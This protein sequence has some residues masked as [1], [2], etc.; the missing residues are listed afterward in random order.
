MSHCCEY[1][2]GKKGMCPLAQENS[3]LKKQVCIF[4]HNWIPSNK[5]DTHA[6]HLMQSN[7]I[8]CVCLYKKSLNNDTL[9]SILNKS[10][11]KTRLL[12]NWRKKPTTTQVSIE[13]TPTHPKQ[14]NSCLLAKI[15]NPNQNI[16]PRL[17]Y[18]VN[19]NS[20]NQEKKISPNN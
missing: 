14:I 19:K 11:F 7:M 9:T 5:T 15:W 4:F 2:L 6:L 12:K 20:K 1:N 16:L 3:F 10:M 8:M 13:K 17:I 18:L